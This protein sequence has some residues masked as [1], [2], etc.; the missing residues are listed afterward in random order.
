MLKETYNIKKL[1]IPTCQHLLL[2][3]IQAEKKTVTV[4]AYLEN[5]IGNVSREKL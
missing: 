5:L 4:K 3:E 2:E 1:V